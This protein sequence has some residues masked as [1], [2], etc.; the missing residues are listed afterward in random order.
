MLHVI[1]QSGEKANE[2]SFRPDRLRDEGDPNS[3]PVPVI[4]CVVQC[5][6][7]SP[8]LVEKVTYLVVV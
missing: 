7:L 1:I 8:S 3:G 6:S 5:T 4:C 2:T